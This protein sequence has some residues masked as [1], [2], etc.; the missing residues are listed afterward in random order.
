MNIVPYEILTH[1]NFGNTKSAIIGGEIFNAYDTVL[2]LNIANAGLQDTKLNLKIQ[3]LCKE[4]QTPGGDLRITLTCPGNCLDYDPIIFMIFSNVDRLAEA[5]YDA[6]DGAV[7]YLADW[8]AP[9]QTPPEL[10]TAIWQTNGFFGKSATFASKA[11]VCQRK[12][13]EKG[14]VDLV[15]HFTQLSPQ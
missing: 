11:L 15:P 13:N 1:F 12:I 10:R 6:P 4:Y 5:G 9:N 3:P 2:R 14:V 8:F 7:G